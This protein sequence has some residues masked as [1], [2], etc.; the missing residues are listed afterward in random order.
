MWLDTALLRFLSRLMA[1]C[2]G[3]VVAFLAFSYLFEPRVAELDPVR[4]ALL[5]VSLLVVCFL[6]P[7]IWT[8]LLFSLEAYRASLR[9][10][11]MA[12]T[13]NEILAKPVSESKALARLRDELSTEVAAAEQRLRSEWRF[14][15]GFL[16]ATLLA[17]M[18]IFA[19]F[20]AYAR[21]SE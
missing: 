11:H 5:R 4:R 6:W 21:P 7:F 2:L 8:A 18:A 3:S 17:V 10:M 1:G 13:A 19:T 12:G 16:V 15:V 9:L 20:V 14:A